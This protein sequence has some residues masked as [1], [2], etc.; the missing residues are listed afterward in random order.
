MVMFGYQVLATVLYHIE[1]MA[2]G[3]IQ[4][5]DGHG[6]QITTG[7]GRHFIMAAGSTI[8]IMAGYGYRM[9]NGDQDG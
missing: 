7:D 6:F 5:M 2:T 4:N 1:P 9:M 3:S 8:L